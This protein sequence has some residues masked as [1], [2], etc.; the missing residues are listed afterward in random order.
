MNDWWRY[1]DNLR[2]APS[3]RGGR[4]LAPGLAQKIIFSNFVILCS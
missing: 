2:L 3:R 4:L 1:E